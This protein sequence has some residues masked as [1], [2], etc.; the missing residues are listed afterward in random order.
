MR[1]EI[2]VGDLVCLSGGSLAEVLCPSKK[3][4][5]RWEVRIV[6]PGPKS[7]HKKGDRGLFFDE[8]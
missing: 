8:P 7:H 1:K 6:N 5:G 3:R 2:K 4:K